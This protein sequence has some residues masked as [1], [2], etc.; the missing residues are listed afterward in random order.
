MKYNSETIGDVLDR[1]NRQYFLPAIQREFEWKP[2]QVVALFDSLLRGYPI[3]SFLFW[4]L[5]DDNKTKWPAYRFL[6]AVKAGGTRNDLASLESAKDPVLILDGQQRLTS[7]LVGLRGQYTIKK[8]HARRKNP[9]AYQKCT[10]YI[11]L[12]HDPNQESP[13][14]DGGDADNYYR[15]AF[16]SKPS[17]PSKSEMWYPV[18]RILQYRDED[19]FG[20]HLEETR[21]KV[22]DTG[23]DSRL[24]KVLRKN[25]SRL[26]QTFW[27]D[28]VVSYYTERE[29]DYDRVLDIFVRTNEGG[30]KLSKSTILM[31]MLTAKWQTIDARD[32]IPAF[33][34]ELNAGLP[35]RKGFSKDFVLK[36]LLVLSDLPV[37]FKAENFSDENLS[38]ME[39]NW[40][41]VRESIRRGVAAI[42]SFMLPEEAL[43]SANAMIPVLYFAHKH[44]KHD[45]AHGTSTY[46]KKNADLMRR[47]FI[48]ALLNRVFSGSSDNLLKDIRD[49]LRDAEVNADFPVAAISKEAKKSG[50][51]NPFTFDTESARELV[52]EIEYGNPMAS[53]VLSLTIGDGSWKD[54]INDVDHIFP[55]ARLNK[56]SLRE[57]GVSPENAADWVDWKNCL[58]NL[59]LLTQ[60]ENLQKSKAEFEKWMK[61]R[62]ASFVKTHAIPE[63]PTLWRLDRFW[64]FTEAREELLVQRLVGLF[65]T[66]S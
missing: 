37:G 57:A 22:E 66:E 23:V 40:P 50:P 9:D 19:A 42:R 11:D 27:K 13:G 25:M 44:P 18:G 64:D 33:V 35:S 26:H 20:D 55:R 30:T 56:K 63:D 52:E 1:L 6:E 41:K 10:L 36:A 58:A 29:Q 31:S 12:L 60:Q 53:V 54:R 17:G 59:Q 51:R 24:L 7:L 14:D 2:E 61:S 47:W 65:G 5:K 15:L 21:E 32:E 34:D 38:L 46:E 62:D 4:E 28:D 16:R 45:F 49:V 39:Q 48:V 3:G 8:K 43:S